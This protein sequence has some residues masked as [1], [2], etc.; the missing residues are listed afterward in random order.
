MSGVAEG[1][2]SFS[3]ARTAL[4]ARI[5]IPKYYDPEIATAEALA[6]AEFALPRL[7]DLLLPGAQGSR[8]GSW[9]R[10]EHYGT[11]PIPFVRTSDLNGWRVRPD[12][13]K[14]VSKDVYDQVSTRQDVRAGDILFVAHGTYLVGTVAV[15]TEDDLPLVLQDHV[16]RL[17]LRPDAEAPGAG[18]V[19]VW[20]ALAAL[21][22]RFVRRQVR[23]RQFSADIIDKIGERH[24]ELRLPIPRD[25]T[26]RK[27]ASDAVRELVEGQ[28]D[29]RRNVSSLLGSDMRMTRERAAARHGFSV[30]RA[31]LA[32]RVL[33]PKYYDPT[34]RSDLAAEEA[35]LAAR[36][37]PIG[38]LIDAGLLSA[39]TGVE[40]GKMAYG[41]G[42]IPFL[43]TTDI[44]ELEI[45]ADP[46]QG[47]SQAIYD[48]HATRASVA[49]GDVLLVRDGTYL[50]GSSALAGADDAP[51]LVCGGIYRLRTRDREALSPAKLL[52]LLNL[53]L[54]RRQMR[55][56]QFT[57]DVIDTLGKRLLEVRVPDPSSPFATTLGSGMEAQMAT[58]AQLRRRLAETVRSLE[59]ALPPALRGRPGWSMRG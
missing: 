6:E 43:R 11:G 41:T 38:E 48:E 33:I 54:V 3:V 10:R 49:E 31:T 5:L 29:A 4:R 42:T 19:D 39:E 12:Y 55:S 46:R 26:R 59:P 40:V 35:R 2:L 28:G 34:L 51:A 25:A 15:V 57:R 36:W 50:V 14:G 37:L 21:S 27:A 16:F 47:V 52:G 7:G 30:P 17:R 56:K 32:K 23:I 1:H 8:L 58:K 22:T 24:L 13:K 44:A 9:I 18:P 53:P 45:K 20:L